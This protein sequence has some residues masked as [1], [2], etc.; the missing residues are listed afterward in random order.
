MWAGGPHREK[1]MRVDY[2]QGLEGS[3]VEQG[4]KSGCRERQ[5]KR[6]VEQCSVLPHR[7]PSLPSPSLWR[8][9]QKQQTKPEVANEWV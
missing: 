6:D 1:K 2:V 3:G 8:Y 4:E 5:G 7:Q 9:M